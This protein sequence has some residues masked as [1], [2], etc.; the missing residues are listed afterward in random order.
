MTVLATTRRRTVQ[1]LGLGGVTSVAGCTSSGVDSTEVSASTVERT[2]SAAARSVAADP[3]DVPAPLDRDEA[4]HHDVTVRAEEVTAEAEEGV[5]FDFMTFDGQ[6]P[7]PMLRV[8]Q[9]DTM[10]FTLENPP[11]NARSPPPR[12]SRRGSGTRPAPAS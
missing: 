10:A 6:I 11:E 7:G 3:T 12:G 1:A 2:G 8:R 5:T 4:K 9:G